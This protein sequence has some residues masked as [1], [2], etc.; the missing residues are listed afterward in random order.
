M[1][2]GA[3]EARN[4][5]HEAVACTS[6]NQ[7]RNAE[8]QRR[9]D[10]VRQVGF[11]ECERGFGRHLRRVSRHLR[12]S[13][14]FREQYLAS[15]HS[16]RQL[17]LTNG[18]GARLKPYMRLDKCKPR[19]FEHQTIGRKRGEERKGAHLL[20][21]DQ[22]LGKQTAERVADHDRRLIEFSESPHQILLI[23]GKTGLPELLA[24]LTRSMAA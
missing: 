21:P 4:G 6:Y 13:K 24:A 17:V 15:R 19:P 5:R 8:E 18:A 16:D 9:R 1:V 23:V 3:P 14:I 10:R 22:H 11:G 20:A 12:L 7:S 2:E